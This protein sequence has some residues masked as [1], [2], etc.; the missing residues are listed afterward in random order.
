MTSEF[1][2]PLRLLHTESSLGWGGQ[3]IRILTEAAGMIKR[4][5]QVQLVCPPEATLFAAAQDQGVPV[6]SLPIAR[7]NLTGLLAL[8]H[9]LV[10]TQPD[11]IITH[12][13]T[14]SWLTAIAS[15]LMSHPPPMVRL[16]HLS[17]PVHRN[18][19]THWLYRKASRL[20]ITTGEGIRQRLIDVN[21]VHP[22][23]TLSIPTGIDLEKFSP[24]DQH[25]ARVVVGLPLSIPIIGIVATLRD[26]KG[27]FHLLEAFAALRDQTA[28][29]VIIGDG[30]EYDALTQRII[31]LAIPAQRI[32][33]T[34]RQEN[35]PDWLRAMDLFVLPSWG[36]EGVPQALMQAMA[37]G[38]P[39]I[40]TPVGG[41]PE[42]IQHDITGVLTPP[43][44]SPALS[45]AM[46]AL[47]ADP[48]RRQQLGEAALL[49]ARHQCSMETML[50]KMESALYSVTTSHKLH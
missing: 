15:L 29:L 38:L 8:R 19:P 24:G 47:L 43:K 48:Q 20:I 40:S 46:D 45:R 33:M 4:G 34:G 14:D 13:S 42:L 9:H 11:V 17:T 30:P 12:S 44:D 49:R 23:R 5:F 10:T 28:Q 39:V 2:A 22:D 18:I 3:E 25:Q 16:R 31:Q 27:H 21:G 1:Q 32:L 6:T 26:W 7:K 37:C 41:I 36:H 50:N 35:I